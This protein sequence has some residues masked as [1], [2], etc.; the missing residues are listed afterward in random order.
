MTMTRSQLSST[1]AE[2]SR[3]FGRAPTATE[4]ADALGIDRNDVVDVLVAHRRCRAYPISSDIGVDDTT[5]VADKL[6]RW[7]ATLDRIGNAPALRRV[8]AELPEP[9]FTVVMLRIFESSPQSEIADRL[10]VSPMLVSRL[11]A[12]ALEQLRDRLQ[13]CV[14]ETQIA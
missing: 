2:L 13:G 8:L 4:L 1:S 7:D 12:N 9:E 3:Q 10:G 11:L 6:S 14:E 5:A